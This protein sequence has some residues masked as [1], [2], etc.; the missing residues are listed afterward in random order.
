MSASGDI[1]TT[2]LKNNCVTSAELAATT[3]TASQIAAN[4]I[5][6]AQLAANTVGINQLATA[7]M[8]TAQ[9]NLTAAQVKALN[10]TPIQLVAAQGAGLVVFVNSVVVSMVYGTATYSCNASGASLFYG[11]TAAG[12]ACGVTVTQAFIQLSSGTNFAYIRGNATL[13][14]DV[15]ANLANAPVT[16]KAAT[17]DP[18]TGDSLVKILVYYK[19]VTLPLT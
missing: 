14:T 16:I 18:T 12:Q 4:T 6:N 15:T 8:Q 3:I 10:T 2:S 19:V 9:V 1:G 13:M 17:S 11:A 7:V 5:T